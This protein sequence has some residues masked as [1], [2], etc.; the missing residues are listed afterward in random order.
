MGCYSNGEFSAIINVL[1]P[2][3]AGGAT[4]VRHDERNATKMTAH[5]EPEGNRKCCIT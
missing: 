3:G 5:L 1:R 4:A 2:G